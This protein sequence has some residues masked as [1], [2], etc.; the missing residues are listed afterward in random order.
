MLR[1]LLALI[2]GK[3]S[4]MFC[5]LAIMLYMHCESCN[6][7]SK[8]SAALASLEKDARAWEQHID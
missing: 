3:Q 2:W 5:T 1:S 4:R 6:L 8:V 7:V